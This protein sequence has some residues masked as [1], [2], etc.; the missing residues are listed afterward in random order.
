MLQKTYYV[1]QGESTG[2]RYF[3]GKD[4]ADLHRQLQKAFPIV[5]GY[6]G[7]PALP[8]AMWLLEYDNETGELV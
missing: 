5:K 1:A 8:E 7:R 2:T 6:S 3:L 4:K